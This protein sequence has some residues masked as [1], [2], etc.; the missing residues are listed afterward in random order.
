MKFLLAVLLAL[1]T[2]PDPTFFCTSCGCMIEPTAWEPYNGLRE[3]YCCGDDDG[4]FYKNIT[5][6]T[7]TYHAC[8]N[9]SAHCIDQFEKECQSGLEETFT[10]CL[11]GKDND[12][13]GLIDN[14]DSLCTGS[15]TGTVKDEKGLPVVGAIVK[16]SPPAIGSKYEVQTTT[17]EVGWYR[18]ESA[19]I[20]N[21][22]FIARK[23]GYD[24]NVTIA[25][26]SPLAQTTKDFILRNGSCHADCTDYYGNCN[27][28]CEGVDFGDD[29]CDF[30]SP[31]CYN[32]P[33]DFVVRETST[34]V[35]ST[36]IITEYHCCEG[37]PP[38][39]IR[40]YQAY[41]P[42][43]TGDVEN[44]YDYVRVLKLNNKTVRLHI[45][46]WHPKEK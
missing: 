34:A 6:G 19:I 44:L 37:M 3:E 13:D 26:I 7:E 9:D 31:L 20:G 1:S 43:V 35:D 14:L 27:P 16:G 39:T 32:R 41:Q 10:L 40:T 45:A 28:A 29:S 18:I 11:D 17:N 8:C 42:I 33:K 5:V 46:V 15:I 23:E 24:D 30:I 12:C 4:E 22:P 21:Y 25:A 2:S 38:G 36:A